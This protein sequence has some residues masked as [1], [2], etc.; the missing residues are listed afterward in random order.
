MADLREKIADTLR[1]NDECGL[2]V[3][4]REE[5]LADADEILRLVA[6]HGRQS[7]VYDGWGILELMGHRRL[8]GIVTEVEVAGAAMIRIDVPG[9]GEEGTYA[10]QLYSPSALYCLTPTTEE[11]ARAVARH[12]RPQPVQ[13]WEL[14][15]AR[16]PEI[17][18]HDGDAWD[19]EI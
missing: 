2:C 8:G 14:P 6:E 12:N 17:V 18:S 19:D 15:A 7:G 1:H 3:A 10:T 4:S 11:A 5:Y 13:R 9:E 16:E